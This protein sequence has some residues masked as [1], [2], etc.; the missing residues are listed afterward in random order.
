[1]TQ[2]VD[3]VVKWASGY[4]DGTGEGGSSI[5][6]DINPIWIGVG[7]IAIAIAILIVWHYMSNRHKTGKTTKDIH[8]SDKRDKPRDDYGDRYDDRDRRED[9]DRR[10]DYHS[11]RDKYYEKSDSD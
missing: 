11:K 8:R 6:K 10:D 4:L 9:R 5:F 7:I 2:T 1:M 3:D